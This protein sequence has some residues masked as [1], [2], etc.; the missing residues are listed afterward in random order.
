MIKNYHSHKRNTSECFH[1]DNKPCS[2]PN[3][4]LKGKSKSKNKSQTLFL[5]EKSARKVS[6]KQTVVEELDE[7][8]QYYSNPFFAF[9][10]RESAPKNWNIGLDKIIEVQD[11]KREMTSHRSH[12]EGYYNPISY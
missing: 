4:P 7:P 11:S 8:T 1:K 2:I 6:D 3:K 12:R 9:G 10:K 5:I